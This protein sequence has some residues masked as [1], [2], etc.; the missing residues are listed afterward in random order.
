MVDDVRIIFK[1]EFNCLK[2]HKAT[3][4]CV[5]GCLISGLLF[6]YQNGASSMVG[7]M[8]G[9]TIIPTFFGSLCGVQIISDTIVK[10]KRENTLDIILSSG[11]S[12]YS[13]I[14]GKVLN[15]LFVAYLVAIL[16]INVLKFGFYFTTNDFNYIT[17]YWYDFINPLVFG[18]LS[19]SASIQA[20][21]LLN[22]EKFA[23]VI[24][25]VVVSLILYGL[26]KLL[27]LIGIYNIGIVIMLGVLL[28]FIT[29]FLASKILN[30]T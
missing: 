18:Y 19:L 3:L 12:E 21:L 1:N 30:K 28:C 27:N 9:I 29:T 2:N 4:V 22:D 16:M 11:I 24:A 7:L 17:F 5:V 10:E 14:I 26:I 6:I 8:G 25:I 15:G 20:Y 13:I 23:P